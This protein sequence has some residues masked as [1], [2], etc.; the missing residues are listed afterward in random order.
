MSTAAPHPQALRL[1]E[2]EALG[3]APGEFSLAA[4]ERL[5]AALYGAV[6]ADA[7][8]TEALR[9]MAEAFD[10]SC[11]MLVASGQGQRDSSF[12]AAWNHPE[13]AVR[14]YAEHWWRHDPWLAQG[15]ARGFFVQGA[16]AR[17]SDLVAPPQLRASAFY[18]E[19][20]TTLPAEHLLICLV[21]D[22][23]TPGMAP[24][25]HLCFLRRPD[26]ADFSTDDVARLRRL[27]PHVLRAF[28]LHWSRRRLEDQVTLLHRFLDAFDFGLLMLDPAATVTYANH[29]ARE[30]AATPALT[31]WLGSLPQRVQAHEPLAKLVRSCAHGQGGG[32]V[33]GEQTPELIV[34]A[35]PVGGPTAQPSACMLL[36]T[37]YA[38]MPSSALDFV[39]RTFG[40]SQAEARL[41]PLLLD[42]NAPADIASELGIKLSTVRTQLSAIFAKTGAMRQQDLIR[43]LGSVPPVSL[44]EKM[45]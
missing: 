21:S 45:P 11:A 8:W 34:L 4:F 2:G 12:Y 43:L 29:A 7:A 37:T 39:I 30:L 22:G 14:A 24:T 31:R 40:L 18:R 5:Q 32:R 26:Q 20:L 36:L 41:L 28:D 23:L 33:L 19:Y 16:I 17:G 42:G 35:L 10:A 3:P 25:A 15:V 38:H 9:V 1:A 27:Y 44:L 6:G 13:A